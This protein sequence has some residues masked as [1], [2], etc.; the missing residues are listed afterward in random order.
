MDAGDATGRRPAPARLVGWLPDGTPHYAAF[1]RVI[2]AGDHV[3]CHLCGRWFLSVASHVRV[4]GWTKDDYLAAFG[5]E[6]G[7]TLAGEATHKRRA[8]AFT[9]RQVIEPGIQQA[10]EAARARA[11]SGEPTAAA[12]VAARGRAHCA[13]RRAKT[14]AA[15]AAIDNEARAAGT[16][17]RARERLDAVAAAA[18]ADLGFADFTSYVIDRLSGGMSMA[19]ISR[20]VAAIAA[21][22]S[23]SRSCVQATL[24]RHGIPRTPHAGKRHEAEERDRRV[25]EAVG[26]RSLRGYIAARR[27]SGV[28]WAAMAVETGLPESTLRRRS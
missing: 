6:A 26:F 4:H 13:E 25:L 12:A 14:I 21:E 10:Q 17:R 8:A 2:T 7:N 15:L 19:A 28:A 27:S 16:R 23:F 1:G 11:R 20:S 3:C 18:A 24:L 22:V 9:A 5:L